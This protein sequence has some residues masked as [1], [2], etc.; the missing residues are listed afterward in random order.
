MELYVET[1]VWNMRVDEEAVNRQ[2]RSVTE[3]FFREVGRGNHGLFISPLVLSE[4]AADPSMEHR[5]ALRE[6]IER[7][8]PAILEQTEAVLTLGRTFVERGI[9][10]EKYEDDG[11]HIAYAILYRLDAIISWNM[12]HIV[13]IRTRREVSRYCQDT[14]LH[15]PEIA[16]PE[17]V[18][19]NV[20]DVG[21]TT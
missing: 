12:A 15:I 9:V 13:K 19:E 20:D 3:A 7:W 11:V 6:G 16:T 21:N 14:G 4:V 18:I 2:K 5:I 17:E 10:P 8:Q 1:S